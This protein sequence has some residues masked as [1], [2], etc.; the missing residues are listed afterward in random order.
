MK[1]K[2]KGRS[3]VFIY[4][5]HFGVSGLYLLIFWANA[6]RSAMAVAADVLSENSQAGTLLFSQKKHGHRDN[7]RMGSLP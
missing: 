3:E 7:G 2:R 6:R 4:S 5:A 1:A